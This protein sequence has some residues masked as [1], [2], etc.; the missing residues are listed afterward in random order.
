M[1]PKSAQC[2][3]VQIA[4]PGQTAYLGNK[5]EGGG[6]VR[7]RGG[8]GDYMVI[9]AGGVQCNHDKIAYRTK[10]LSDMRGGAEIFGGWEV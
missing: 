1:I 3:H 10:G 7:W 4:Y 8:M 6:E 5:V 2:N 9:G